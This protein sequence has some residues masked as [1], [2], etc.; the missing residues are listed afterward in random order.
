VGSL[1]GLLE[2]PESHLHNGTLRN[3][4]YHSIFDIAGGPCNE[5]FLYPLALVPVY[6]GFTSA[7]EELCVTLAKGEAIKTHQ[8]YTDFLLTNFRKTFPDFDKDVFTPLCATDRS[9]LKV[10]GLVMLRILA[11]TRN[12]YTNVE[13]LLELLQSGTVDLLIREMSGTAG[14]PQ[15][16]LYYA[17]DLLRMGLG[18]D[19]KDE[20]GEN[21]RHALMALEVLFRLVIVE[22]EQPG[23]P[24]LEQYD[25]NVY[26]LVEIVKKFGKSWRGGVHLLETSKAV[27]VTTFEHFTEG[28]LDVG[29]AYI[30]EV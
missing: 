27:K 8:L 3:Y 1:Q 13:K 11:L 16:M 15:I 2:L 21:I 17:P 18:E 28:I 25:L 9:F 14:S 5:R 20:S 26:P 29:D 6:M 22:V 4:L 19:M 23:V 30:V 7:M 24:E 10:T 12:T